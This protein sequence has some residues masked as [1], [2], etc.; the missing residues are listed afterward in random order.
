VLAIGLGIGSQVGV[1]EGFGILAMASVCPIVSVLAVGLSVT[2]ARKAA[3]T[4]A[5]AQ[6][7]QGGGA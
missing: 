6:A 7:V 3:L 2:R 5:K 1:V 4:D